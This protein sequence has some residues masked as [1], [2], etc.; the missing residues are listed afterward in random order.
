MTYGFTLEFTTINTSDSITS[1]TVPDSTVTVS[2]T[3][4]F[5][6]RLTGPYGKMETPHIHL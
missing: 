2:P 5:P 1:I 3:G 4:L 6:N